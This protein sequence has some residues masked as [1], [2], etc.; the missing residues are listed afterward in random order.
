MC[1]QMAILLSSP[2]PPPP[3]G[4]ASHSSSMLK[5]TRKASRLRSLATRPIGEKR[6][7]GIIARDKMDVTYENWKHVPT[8]QKD[9]IREDIQTEFDIPE[10]S[11]SAR[12]VLM[13]LYMKSMTLA[14]RNRPNFVRA[15]ETLHGRGYEYL[16]KKLIDE[17]RKKK[18]EEAAQFGSTD[19]VIDPPS[20]IRQH[21]KWKLACIKKTGHIASEAAKEIADKNASQGSFVAHGHH[22]VLN[23]VIGRLEHPG[24]VRAA[25]AGITIK[26]YFG[27]APRTS[28]TSSSMAP[29]DLQHL[30]QQIRD[31]LEDSI[32]KKMQSQGLAL[33]SELEVGPSVDRVSTKKSCV[34]PS[35]NNPDTGYS[36]K[37][38]LYIKENPPRLVALGRVYEGST[39]VYNIPL[40]HDQV[41]VGVEEV[42]DA[43]TPI[44]VPTEE[45][46]VVGQALNTFLA[47]STHLGAVGLVKPVD[48]PDHEVDD[49]LCLMTLII[50]QLFLKPLQVKW[51]A[52]L[53]GLFNEDFPLYIKHEDLFEIAHGGQ[54]LSISVIQL[55]I[56]F[57][58]SQFESKSYIKNWMQNSKWDVHLGAYLNGL[59][60]YL[61]GIINIA[62][63][64]LNDTQ[65]SKSKLAIRFTNDVFLSF[66]GKD[67]RHSFT[68]NL[69]KALSERGI[70]TFIDD[71]KLPRGDEITS[72]LEKAI[73]ESRIFIIVLSENYAWSSFCLNELDY[74]LKFIKGKGLLVLPVFY[75]VDPSDV[76]NHTGSFGESLAYHEKKFKSTNN[77]EKLE[78]WKMALNQVANLS[79]YHHFKHG[80][81]YEYQF[82]QRI[83]ELVS[84]R[85]NRAPLHVADYPVG[86]E[87]RIQEVKMLLDVGSDDVV[88]M[89]G[90]HGLGGIGKTTLA[91]AIYN[92][93][94]DH[95]EA[96]CFLEN[97]RE[98]SKTHGLQ[99]L[100][101]NLLSKTVG[102]DELIG[103]K[104][105]ISIIQHRLQQKK[106]LLILDDVDKREQLQALVGR[107]DLFCPGSRVI[108]TTRDKQLLACH[109][110]KRTYEVN[111]LNEEYAL[112]LLSW[113]AFKLEK[114]NPC[115]KDVLNRAVTYSAGLPLALEVIGSNLSGRNIEQW[116]S[117]LDRYKR[118]PNKEI[119]EILKVSYDALEED[120]QSVFLDISCCLKEYDLK[121][122]QDILRAHYGHC[123]EHHIRVLLEKSLIKISDGYITLHD[124]IEDMGKEIVRKES[125]REPGKRSRLWLHTDIIQV[126]EEN[127]GTSQIEIICTD[128]SLFEE[129]EIEWDANA[130][131]KMENLKT[132][133]IKN[134]HFT[135]GPKHLPDTLRVLEW[136]RYP[137]QSF[138]SDFRPKKLAICKLPNSGYTSLELAVLL[139]K[140]SK[141]VNLT[142][143]NFDSCQHLTQIPDVSCVP[144]LE[145][146]SFKDCDNLHAIHQSVGLLEK[147]RILEAEEFSP[148]KL[149]S[150]E[151]LRLGFCHSLESFPEILGKM[152]NIIH[153]NLE[154]TPVKK[155]PLSFRNLTRLHTLFVCF[156]RNQTNGCKDILVSS[157]CTMPKG[158]RVIGVGWEGCQFSKE[159][160]GA[161]NVSLTTSSNVQFLDLRNC[162]LSD[163]FFPI[164]LPCF[165][166]VKE[167]DLSGNNF[168]VIPECIKE[169]RFLTVLYLNYCER[170]R[171]IRGIPP[172]L[173]YFYAEECL[174][175]T[176]S[177]RSMLLSQELHEA[178]RT[179]F[180]LPGAKIPEWFDFQTSEFPISFWFRN[181]FPAIAICHI[182]KRVA[183]FS[184]SRGWTFRPNIRTKVIIN[185]NANLFIPVVLGSD[186]SCLFDL[187]GKR[188]TDNLDEAL[189]ENEWNH[190]E[191]TCPGFT[192]TFAPTFIKT[193]LHVLKQ[194]SDMEDIRFSDPCRKTKLDNDFN[195]SKPENQRW[196]GNDVA[197]TQVVQQQKLMG[198]FLSRMWHWALVFLISFLVFLISCRRNNQ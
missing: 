82:I 81:E 172:N 170:L 144:K 96:L 5:Q 102:E 3:I 135:K 30:T 174:S 155:F 77:M 112:Q 143:L 21:V 147:L 86:L 185:G 162:N 128:F 156:P 163:D 186:C 27:S 76:R 111:E 136:W 141:F 101:R 154:Q 18:L 99:Y 41:K 145:K 171:E 4:A 176:S 150:L 161:E 48:R 9:L 39:I 97:V 84:K 15:A 46:K 116:R 160:E 169:C 33:P 192:F 69:Y 126:L 122:V 121:E 184:S 115:Y 149:T 92:S 103:V 14:T 179:F 108:I 125:P 196:V 181:K 6:P 29:E 91:A 25:G 175:L 94:A 50:P 189:L 120:E 74:I 32:T 52:T 198:S 71:K 152:E 197:K 166:N 43:D 195:S 26:Q 134:G 53:F 187:R 158:S 44:P 151:Q 73:E 110:V 90:I 64:G 70:N 23:A 37:C 28:C 12:T 98:T 47:W 13:I 1:V 38:G 24:R 11:D 7:L 159:D 79:G 42:R 178:G 75:K 157:I 191:V 153:L 117:T 8:A 17:K 2:S 60:N 80:E 138:P 132:L 93:I 57:G 109:G 188:V 35:G 164:A 137:S 107:P 20:L 88:H 142:N 113:K 131:K 127:K 167:L 106:V 139:K 182:I 87:S 193:G 119:Q 180:Y 62:L 133:I 36:G 31:Q 130:F 183:E 66:R 10:P 104:Q 168:T 72:A 100:Q 177:C 40:L 190:A 19:T 123:M 56:L 114:V 105:G 173:K 68:G 45:V 78:T 165:A 54:C 148:I 65:Q 51:D 55:W 58:Q 95:F 89:V 129:V 59:D 63:K 16:E 85:I 118:I 83:V 146:L 140:A 67:T 61:K 34:D 124:L 49:P 194:E 22:D